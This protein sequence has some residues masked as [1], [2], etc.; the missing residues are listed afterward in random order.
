MA[1]RQSRG[2]RPVEVGLAAGSERDVRRA[3]PRPRLRKTKRRRSVV[4]VEINPV[5][6]AGDTLQAA[7]DDR[8][9]RVADGAENL[10]I[11]LEV[12]GTR[13]AVVRV[14]GSRAVAPKVDA[15]AIVS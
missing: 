1:G 13:V 2:G 4:V 12:V 14:V 10:G 3:D 7:A 9:V 15:D 6:R 5:G 8:P 11:V